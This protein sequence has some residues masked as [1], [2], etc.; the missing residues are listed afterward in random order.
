MIL[1]SNEVLKII[2]KTALIIAV[3]KENI[4]IIKLLIN[5][6]K[7]DVNIP[8]IILEIFFYRIHKPKYFIKYEHYS[9]MTFKA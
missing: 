9:F 8:S 1:Y 2:N 6:E 4:E 7:T 3:E 5:N